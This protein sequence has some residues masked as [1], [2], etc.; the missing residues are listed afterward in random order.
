MPTFDSYVFTKIRKL[1]IAMISYA[2]W[3]MKAGYRNRAFHF[4]YYI[5]FRN[6]KKKFF[7]NV[8]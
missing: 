2:E 7:K 6:I 4:L 3:N 1:H 8:M 5:T